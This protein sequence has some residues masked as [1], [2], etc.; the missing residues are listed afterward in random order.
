MKN[1]KYIVILILIVLLL[2][3]GCKKSNNSLSEM[4]G[5]YELIEYKTGNKTYKEDVLKD[6]KDTYILNV[7]TNNQIELGMKDGKHYLT[8]DAH[9]F[10]ATNADK[11]EEKV[12]YSYR[13]NKIK[14]VYDKKTYIYKKVKITNQS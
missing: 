11:K 10:Y 2:V 7:L 4:V 5:T 6:Y 13:D 12:K 9:Y 14:I 8:Y 3:T 1:K